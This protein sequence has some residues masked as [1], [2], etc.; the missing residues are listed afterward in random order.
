MKFCFIVLVLS[1]NITPTN[2]DPLTGIKCALIYVWPIIK[3]QPIAGYLDGA[4]L[5]VLAGY[6]VIVFA[7]GIWV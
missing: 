5:G 2:S 1:I 7:V 4:D 6:F 3:M